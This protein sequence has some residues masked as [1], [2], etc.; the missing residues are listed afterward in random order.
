[1]AASQLAGL[2]SLMVAARLCPRHGRNSIKRHI[3]AF[4]AL[5]HCAHDVEGEKS[6]N[7]CKWP[8][9]EAWPRA[10]VGV[11]WEGRAQRPEGSR[12][13]RPNKQKIRESQASPCHWW[14]PPLELRVG[15]DETGQ[16]QGT[17]ARR[18]CPPPPQFPSLHVAGP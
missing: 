9:I 11:L 12:E 5:S 18:W 16:V 10:V 4:E 13:R 17:L 7:Q 8:R 2:D 3:V 1:M 15:A 14:E 6:N